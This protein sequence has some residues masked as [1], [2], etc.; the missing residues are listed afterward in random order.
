[1][2]NRKLFTRA[3]GLKMEDSQTDQESME[4]HELLSHGDSGY[5]L[6]RYLSHQILFSLITYLTL[7]PN[8]TCMKILHV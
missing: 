2:K 1:M 6:L 8:A 5:V 4:N 3:I 7:K